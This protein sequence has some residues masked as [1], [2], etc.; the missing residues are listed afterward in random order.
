[1]VSLYVVYFVSEWYLIVFFND[2]VT[3][4]I[5][6]YWNSLSLHYALPFSGG[7]AAKAGSEEGRP[8]A[9]RRRKARHPE[10]PHHKASQSGQRP[11]EPCESSPA[12]LEAAASRH[13]TTSPCGR[14]PTA[15]GRRFSISGWA[16]G[17]APRETAAR[18]EGRR[19]GKDG[20]S[21]M[22]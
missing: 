8:R 5:Y 13:P 1:M 7:C 17:P 19:A 6:T 22:N 14:P 20:V 18:S 3:P 11:P 2:S 15:R 9:D 10:A 12:V 21:T 4:Q 16:A